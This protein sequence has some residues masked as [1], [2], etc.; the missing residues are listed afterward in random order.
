MLNVRSPA[1]I[2]ED[3]IELLVEEVAADGPEDRDRVDIAACLAGGPPI[4]WRI[5]VIDGLG[6]GECVIPGSESLVRS[7]QGRP[8]GSRTG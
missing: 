6:N 7:P 4:E 1:S 3:D 5:G 8:A 2:V